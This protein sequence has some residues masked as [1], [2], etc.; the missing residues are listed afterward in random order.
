M[1]PANAGSQQIDT[2][3]NFLNTFGDVAGMFRHALLSCG[4]EISFLDYTAKETAAADF[5][6]DSAPLEFSFHM[7]GTG[8]GRIIK[9]GRE[10][11]LLSGISGR[12]LVTY[13]PGSRCSVQTFAG[14][15]YRIL[16]LYVSPDRFMEYL[17]GEPEYVPESFRGI[18]KRNTAS[19]NID[20]ALTP[21][22]RVILD[23]IVNSPYQGAMNRLFLESKS[24][25]LIVHMLHEAEG[26]RLCRNI[27]KLCSSDAG[28]IREARDILI[29]EMDNPPALDD[30]ARRVG[31]NSTKLKKG[32]RSLFNST[33]YS[34]LRSE[35]IRHAEVLLGEG[36]MNITEISHHLGFS[37]TS[38]FIREFVKFHG[39][40]PGRFTKTVS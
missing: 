30:L 26:S 20:A 3:W 37:D 28:R 12:S 18:L 34:V 24:M 7:A 39:T 22:V 2:S 1:L 33:P 9:G 25:E 31:I 17:G 13:N 4:L 15:H 21:A 35:R 11:A 8:Y 19:I 10:T 40:T 5:E 6:I 38:H 29:A 14:E 32:F 27:P 36:L 23:Q 16:N